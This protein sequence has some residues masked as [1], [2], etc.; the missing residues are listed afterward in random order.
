[1]STSKEQI[2]S[3]KY[4]NYDYAPGIA[5][6]GIDGKTGQTGEDGNNIYFTDYDIINSTS[7]LNEM[8][9]K[10]M[11]NILPLV[12]LKPAISYILLSLHQTVSSK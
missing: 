7:D 8:L 1:M 4:N 2:L 9:S 5:T 11:S 10:I 3:Q 12:G 6:Y